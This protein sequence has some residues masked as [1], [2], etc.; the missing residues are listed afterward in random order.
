MRRKKVILNRY[1]LVMQYS[2]NT[3]SEM[4]K[5]DIIRKSPIV[6][7]LFHSLFNMI[8]TE[9]KDSLHWNKITKCETIYEKNRMKFIITIER[10]TDIKNF[11]SRREFV[12][13]A[14]ITQFSLGDTV[15]LK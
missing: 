7:N 1:K 6:F 8:A 13:T 9:K 14:Y 10:C 5:K 3:P 4:R 2:D 15:Y 12:I 11:I